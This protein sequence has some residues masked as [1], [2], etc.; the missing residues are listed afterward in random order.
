M[1]IVKNLISMMNGDLQVES[2]YGKGSRFVI[3]ICLTKCGIPAVSRLK[4]TPTEENFPTLRALLAE[5]NELNRQ[6]N[7]YGN[8]GNSWC[9]GAQKMGGRL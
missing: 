4:N 1:T 7:S 6:E 5:D 8:A 3:T 2:E 9:P